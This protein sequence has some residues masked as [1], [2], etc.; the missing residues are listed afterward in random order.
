MP[1][2]QLSPL[3]YAH[4]GGSA[5]APENTLA[6][7]R[8]AL[9]QQ[10]DGIEL[11]VHLSADGEVVVIHDAD[12][13]RTTNGSGS[14]YKKTLLE[15]KQLD[16]GVWFGEEFLGE[17]VPTLSEVLELLGEQLMINIELKGPG[18]FRS[19]LPEKV[20]EIVRQYHLEGRVVFSSFNPW[21]LRQIGTLLPNAKLGLLLPPGFAANLIRVLSK[22]IFTPWGYHPHY[23]SIT[24]GF[25]KLAEREARP[26]LAWTVNQPDDLAHMCALGVYGI[27]TDF[28]A[29]GLAQ[30]AESIK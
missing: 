16:A 14:V 15:I 25:L 23:R 19:E 13:G 26:V 30:R 24:K 12:L 22:L 9:K 5:H 29:R 6:A 27:I 17:E 28:P 11:D 20:V 8:A 1:N 18:L 21:Q 10:A 4:R 7:F 3:I 2:N